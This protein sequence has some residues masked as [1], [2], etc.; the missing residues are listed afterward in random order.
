M[1]NIEKG[2]LSQRERRIVSG[3]GSFL[4]GATAIGSEVRDRVIF[5][6]TRRGLN[7]LGCTSP[8]PKNRK[9]VGFC[10]NESK[11]AHDLQFEISRHYWGT[12]IEG[13]SPEAQ[14]GMLLDGRFNKFF[15]LENGHFTV[16]AEGLTETE[17]LRAGHTMPNWD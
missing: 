5:E 12:S 10:G 6:A 11:S 9:S 15:T 3:I 13:P 16:T 14:R 2:S 17:K 1:Q 8:D 4:E 7:M